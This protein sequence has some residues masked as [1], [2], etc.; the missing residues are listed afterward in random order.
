MP[1]LEYAMSDPIREHIINL[2][3]HVIPPSQ[4]PVKVARLLIEL[5]KRGVAS[6]EGLKALAGLERDGLIWHVWGPGRGAIQPTKLLALS[7][8][9]QENPGELDTHRG[10]KTT[11]GKKINEKMRAMLE[12]DASSVDWTV[13]KWKE[14]FQ[15][16]GASVVDT[17]AWKII[18]TMRQLRAAEAVG[19]K[20][21][22]I[23][24]RRV[25]KKTRS[26]D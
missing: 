24:R 15:C 23:D 11:K 21:Q 18:M 9:R 25:K 10:P 2:L 12:K 22:R 20:Y 14:H 17:P 8:E 19:Q 16:S 7:R 5:H 4:F 1:T 6:G 26:E 3:S 13:K